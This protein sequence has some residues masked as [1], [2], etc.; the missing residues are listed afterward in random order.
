VFT[1]SGFGIVTRMKIALAPRPTC[2]R[3]MVLPIPSPV[4]IGQIVERVRR[5][6]ARLPGLIG[7]INLLNAHRTLAMAAPY[8]WTDLSPEGLIPTE[9]MSRLQKAYGIA[10]WTLFA[11]LYGT[12][13][14]VDAAKQ[15]LNGI[16]AGLRKR[17]L[18]FSA[19][20]LR[21]TEAVAKAVPIERIRLHHGKR[22]RMLRMAAE[23]AVGYPNETALPLAYWRVRSS[24]GSAPSL[25]P[26][27]DGCGLIWYAPL[28]PM[29]Q[30]A[31]T[32]FVSL[33]AETLPRF[34]LEPLITMTTV[35]DYCFDASIP[36]LFDRA[37]PGAGERARKC[38]D[39]LLE[40]GMKLGFAPYRV[41]VDGQAHLHQRST[42]H[43]KLTLR[44][45]QA[46]DPSDLLSPGR[47]CEPYG[48]GN[49]T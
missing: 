9:V 3:V 33:I 28:I 48:H 46:I 12:A 16:F 2:A 25:N 18:Y 32:R 6:R 44:L 34:S 14:T 22:V 42:A 40:Q 37:N 38:Y 13:R 31:S 29:T 8:P 19:A 26:A 24:P 41:P 23:L 5:A 30:E 43:G 36:L 17:P 20:Q 45:K 35:N 1:Q 49:L 10:D 47:Y 4:D 27:R 21:V 39:V 11:T 7:G 15:E